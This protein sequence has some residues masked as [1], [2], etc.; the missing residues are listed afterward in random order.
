MIPLLLHLMIYDSVVFTLW[1]SNLWPQH[2]FSRQIPTGNLGL[3]TLWLFR[4]GKRVS[5]CAGMPVRE[6]V[7]S[8]REWKDP[9]LSPDPFRLLMKSQASWLLGWSFFTLQG[10]SSTTLPVECPSRE[11][12]GFHI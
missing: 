5:I 4:S 7:Q 3:R 8:Q 12:E 10:L 1:I 2:S 6:V 9:F 11:W